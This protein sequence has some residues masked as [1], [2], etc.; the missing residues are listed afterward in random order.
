MFVKPEACPIC[1]TSNG[2]WYRKKGYFKT[3]YNHQPVPRYQCKECKKFFST[4]TFKSTYRQRKPHL[5]K[6][7]FDLLCS[8]VTLR[9]TAKILGISKDTA[10]VKMA[11]LAEQAHK[12]HKKALQSEELKTSYVQF[13]EMETFEHT[14]LKPISI[15]IAVRA[16]TGQIIDAEVATMNAK[17]HLASASRQIYGLRVDT[18]KDACK[19]V[20]ETVKCIARDEITIASDSKRA[21]PN[22]IREVI[23]HAAI[24]QC[25]GRT[26]ELFRLNHAAAKIRADLARMARKTWCTTKKMERLQDHLLLYIAWNNGYKIT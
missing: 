23:P 25:K 21:Y 22:I 8:G 17:G 1:K 12:A 26:E 24:K 4:H 15:A 5:N 9:R 3:K 7:V 10:M 14:K 18:R 19:S 13:D 2:H 20:I 6:K 16:K 11:F